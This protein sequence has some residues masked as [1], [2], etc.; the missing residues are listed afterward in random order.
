MALETI[1]LLVEEAGARLDVYL[2][3]QALSLT[4]S[5][6]QK[7]VEEGQVLVNGAVKKA[8]YRVNQGDRITL[9]LPEPEE[10]PLE[11]ENIPLDVVYEDS[12]II[13]INKPRG[14]VVH[15]AAGNYTGTLVQA[16][17]YHCEDLSGIG[18][19]ARPGIVHRIDKDTTGLLVVAKNDTAHQSLARQI[20][21]KEAGRV[22]LALVEGRIALPGR[23]EAPIGRDPKDRKRMAVV[24]AGREAATEY[25]PKEQYR[26]ET[27]LELKL[28][29]GRTH[30]IRVHMAH[31]GHPVVGD[32][33]YGYRRQRF[34]LQG[35]L[36]HAWQLHLTHPRTGER[37]TFQAPLP[38]DFTHVLQ[39]LRAREGR[40][41]E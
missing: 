1:N 17:L 15:P 22:Y 39:V 20:Q 4:R 37:M 10:I 12:D 32:P 14:M 29:T 41:G 7:L 13:V 2:A 36:L 34:S 9:S 19:E 8:N 3:G 33:I 24:P 31:I 23:V 6:I 21:L 28:E 35:Q 30:Q 16:L 38:E 25:W 18:G 5:R 27:L 11:P 40:C 26:H